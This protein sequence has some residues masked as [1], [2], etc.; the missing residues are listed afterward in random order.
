LG[1]PLGSI[2]SSNALLFFWG[3]LGGGDSQKST[4]KIRILVIEALCRKRVLFVA[5]PVEERLSSLLAFLP[6]AQPGQ[7]TLA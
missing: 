5:V 3:C 6:L 1:F 2:A 4:K 7:L